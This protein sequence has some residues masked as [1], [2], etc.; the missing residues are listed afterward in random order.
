M[1][2]SE[3][4]KL[5]NLRKVISMGKKKG[6]VTLDELKSVM[7]S[8]MDDKKQLEEITRILEE[9]DIQVVENPSEVTAAL[10][11]ASVVED[12][13]EEGDGILLWSEEEED[14]FR[15][16]GGAD[17]VKMYLQEM[18]NI[19]L[20]SREE[21]I[22]LAKKIEAGRMKA[23]NTVMSI[24][25]TI[26]EL[27]KL[28]ERLENGE[29]DIEDI[30][31]LDDSS[32]EFLEKEKNKFLSKVKKLEELFK[33][34]E[35]AKK[36]I[37]S[38][39]GEKEEKGLKGKVEE[40]R[41]KMVEIVREL[42]LSSSQIER[43][44][45]LIRKYVREADRAQEEMRKCE[46]ILLMPSETFIE[47]MELMETLPE[48]ERNERCK[49]VTGMDYE[50]LLDFRKRVEE[51]KDKIRKIEQESTVRIEELRAALK[52]IEE[53][54]KEE[55]EAK[56]LLAEANLRLVVSIAKKYT[57]KGLQLLDL[58]QEG[59][60]GLMKAVEKFEYQRGYKFSTYATWW[61]RQAITRAIADQARTIRIPVH[62]IETINKLVRT[63][64]QLYQELGREPTPEEIAKKAD[65]PVD[66]V[67]KIFKI[68][69]EPV[70]L[71]TPIGDDEDSSLG[72]FVEDRS[73]EKP[74]EVAVLEALKEKVYQALSTLTEREQTV[75]KMRFGIDMDAEHTL[76]EVGKVFKVTRER[77][78]QIEAKALKKLRNPVDMSILKNISESDLL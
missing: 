24:P 4:A 12:I 35:T 9:M 77:I 44:V 68:A 63:A 27:L 60:I 3:T 7:P 16:S 42:S 57:N 36:K 20:L 34:F 39:V 37:F 14:T 56:R 70:S 50:V 48:D 62:M 73:I 5:M 46:E 26:R 49:R 65:M 66:K 40:L 10:I 41:K 72:D 19:P 1:N 18:G 75:L 52:E 21:E 38:G 32:P 29:I 51:S 76:E 74:D 31:I 8:E 33:D 71:E 45:E 67:R 28:G 6:Y 55:K 54:L 59:N 23:I 47:F 58:I 22:E 25:L 43:L 30:L 11:S 64:R 15:E 61:I 17:P 78:R 53:G 69:K 13:E 2:I